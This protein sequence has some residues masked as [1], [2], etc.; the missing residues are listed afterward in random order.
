M[1]EQI[2]IS[3]SFKD[4][5]V[6]D[7]ICDRLEASGLRCWI[8]PR[9]ILPGND[10]SEAII[11]AIGSSRLMIL[12]HSENAN[13][14]IQIKREVERAVSK[15]VTV[16]PFR[17]EDVSVSKS[18]EYYLSTAY[19]LDAV[20]LP[21][22]P[23][24]EFLDEMVK[25]LVAAD[26]KRAGAG[27][28]LNCEKCGGQ[29]GADDAACKACGW[30]RPSA[31]P[32]LPPPAFNGT[33]AKP[34]GLRRLWPRSRA[35]KISVGATLAL[36]VIAL[37][38]YFVT[39]RQR[40]GSANVE[41]YIMQANGHLQKSEFDHAIEMYSQAISIN[42][43]AAL[44]WRGRAIA[45]ANRGLMRNVPDDYDRALSD[46]SE[47]LS[48]VPN[49]DYALMLR[50]WVYS[51]KGLYDA[52]FYDQSLH[53]YEAAL[54][55]NPNNGM[56]YAGRASVHYMKQEYDLALADYTTA[57]QKLPS[58]ENYFYRG[59]TLVKKG[60]YEAAIK[61]YNE[62]IKLNPS[63]YTFYKSRSFAYSNLGKYDQAIADDK[64]AGL[65]APVQPQ[66]PLIVPK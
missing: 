7:A 31:A 52:A 4:K 63:N 55:L 11:D 59:N 20:S 41:Q 57:I 49:D 48:R 33:R 45:Y 38:L 17:I 37:T 66:P 14:S 10:W 61:D 21:L 22:E 29:L 51:L 1:A 47:A 13:S 28:S 25:R 56:A 43:A 58:P 18:L 35:A 64:Q 15:G 60:D 3:H 46:F 53:D 65:L 30:T 27:A 44:A 5:E 39:G 2:F 42:P 62:A 36:L 12:V 19:W 40:A 6:A 23:H 8:A 34:R 26:T 32:Q 24:L 16:V 9:D 50:A 54:K